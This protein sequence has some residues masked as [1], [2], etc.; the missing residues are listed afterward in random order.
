MSS[1]S[2]KWRIPDAPP[3]RPVPASAK[4]K[5]DNLVGA[6]SDFELQTL[7]KQTQD[8]PVIVDFGAAWCDHCKGI[9]PAFVRMTQ[10]FSKPLFVL[11]DV[12]NVP[13]E[14]KDIRYTPTFSFYNKGR[15]VDE[16]Y[17]VNQQQLRDHIW[18]HT[19]DY[20]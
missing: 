13:T 8:K 12:D 4:R 2:P 3:P 9:L 16:L 11:T 7:I 17:G 5:T 14:S 19:P 15:K 18:L 20:S 10:E 6:T 1:P